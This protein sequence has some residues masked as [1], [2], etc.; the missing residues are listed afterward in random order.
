MAIVKTQRMTMRWAARERGITLHEAQRMYELRG[1]S[2]DGIAYLPESTRRS[3]ARRLDYPDM[4]RARMEWRLEQSKGDGGNIPEQ[5]LVRA[6][7][8]LDSSRMRSPRQPVAGMPTGGPVDS[9][10][11]AGSAAAGP[12][13]VAGL[14]E[15]IWQTLGPANVGGRTR[16]ILLH[17]TIPDKLWAAS[18]GGGIW[19]SIDGGRSWAAVDDFMANLA[20]TSIV[21]DPTNNDH[22]YAGTGEGF[23]NGDAIRGAGIFETIDG[24]AWSRVGGSTDPKFHQ[25]N[26]LGISANGVTLLA[27]TTNGLHRSTDPTRAIWA[28]VALG[29]F[30]DVKFHP[31]DA[32][33]AVAGEQGTGRAW[34]SVDGGATWSESTHSDPWSGRVELC[35]TRADPAIVYASV[36]GGGGTI[37]RST[38]GGKSFVKRLSR[39]TAGQAARYLGDQG[40]YGNAIW[41]GD[42]ADSNLVIVGGVDLWRSV[43]GGNTL[44]EI[45]SWYDPRSAHADHHA[46]VADPGYDGGANRGVWFSNDGGVYYADDV[47]TVGD[48]AQAP[49][50]S[51]WQHRSMGYQVTQ[52]F[53]AAGNAESGMIVAGAQDNGTLAY[54]INRGDLI[55]R[56]IFGGDGGFCCADATDPQVFY[57]QYVYLDLHRNLDGA[58]TGDTAG[59]RYISGHF[60]NGA[61]WDWKPEPFRIPDAFNQRALFIA[62][63]SI[64]PNEENRLLAGGESLWRTNDAKA[65][66][67]ASSGPQWSR[68]KPPASG[69]ISAVAIARGNSDLVWVGHETGQL[70]RS[71][72]AT[73]ALPAWQRIDGQGS[74]PLIATRMCTQITL[75]PHDSRRIFVAFGGFQRD[76]LWRSDDSGTTWQAIAGALPQAPIRAV[77]VHPSKSDWIYVGTEVGIFASED[78][79]AHWSPTNEGPANVSVE[80]LF[81]MGE[82]LVCVTHGRGLFIIDLTGL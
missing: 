51:G 18:V 49:H 10:R 53:A 66:N 35:Y 40:W 79:G 17:P 74:K 70:W 41:A 24:V 47:T 29:N 67:S 45:S 12:E 55:W 16:S 56:P 6:L 58:T 7:E 38:N 33:L 73:T 11:L 39:N 61:S 36:E 52:L 71:R 76:N 3:I 81:W 62:P 80:D 30:T 64:D 21:I 46:I 25:I 32:M 20:V 34:R 19:L 69:K 23:G 57:G 42:P 68:I 54:D 8:Q 5:P 44:Q 31:T 15:R 28:T 14:D 59:D 43:D 37:Y 1:L 77:S 26:R 48:E 27:A 72:D 75:S 9:A 4:P 22:I 65:P 63:F 78:A 13:R 60:W 82:K 2:P 50:V